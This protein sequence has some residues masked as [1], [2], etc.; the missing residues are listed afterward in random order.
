MLTEETVGTR[1][2]NTTAPTQSRSATRRRPRTRK[3]FLIAG[4]IVVAA[5]GYMIYSAAQSGSEYYVTA[6]ELKAMGQQAMSQPTKLGGRVEE[7]SVQWNEGKTSVTFSVTDGTQAVPVKYTGTVPDTFSPG[8][9]VILEGKLA[10]D[11][12]FQASSMMAKC[13]SK[14]EPA[15]K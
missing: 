9:D 7:G 3:R 11:G 8:T 1:S 10:A 14:Y 4:L 15:Q 12:S 2:R 13:A 5:I 6:G